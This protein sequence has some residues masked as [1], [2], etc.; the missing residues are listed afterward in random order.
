MNSLVCTFTKKLFEN[1]SNGYC[2]A[3]FQTEDTSV[4]PEARKKEKCST[5]K[6]TFTGFGY[7]IPAT[8]AIQLELE[9][10][11]KRSTKYGIQFA[12]EQC[13][14]IVPP[15]IEGIVGYLSSGLIRGVSKITARK[16]TD[17]FGLRSLEVI[18]KEPMRLKEICGLS[19]KKI[20]RIVESFSRNKELRSIVSFLA[21]YDISLNK[22]SKIYDQFGVTSMEV[23]N[24]R[25]YQLC[26]VKGFGFLTVDAIALKLKCKPN[27]KM[28]IREC[29]KYLL[30]EFEGKG[31]VY[32]PQQQF[33]DACFHQLN[34][35]LKDAVA[36]DE[37]RTTLTEEIRA[38]RLVNNNGFIYRPCMFKSEVEL[39]KALSV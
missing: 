35:G 6:I 20:E 25:P 16:I 31:H 8:D 38:G 11:W 26:D 37:I 34:K 21:P 4:P 33:R 1:P 13:A 39:A 24:E 30:A 23:L 9:G 36:E 2:V 7:R 18:E 15:T 14:E 19:D 3:L 12:I 10:K 32:V 22:A 27:D 17:K 5:S 28:R 29:A